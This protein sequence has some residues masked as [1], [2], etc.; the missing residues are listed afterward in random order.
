M[1]IAKIMDLNGQRKLG[2]QVGACNAHGS[3]GVRVNAQAIL[4]LVILGK[5]WY[6]H[7]MVA[8]NISRMYDVKK[9]GFDNSFNVTKCL[10]KSSC[11]ID[12]ICAT[13]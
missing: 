5:P 6:L 9:I 4:L 13:I 2:G 11:L 12:Y 10:Q 8:Q 7:K 1:C 3:K